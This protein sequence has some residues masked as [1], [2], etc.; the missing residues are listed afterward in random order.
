MHL[1]LGIIHYCRPACRF[2]IYYEIWISQHNSERES[3]KL[4]CENKGL[5]TNPAKVVRATVCR[6]LKKTTYMEPHCSIHYYLEA[7]KFTRDIHGL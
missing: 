6:I 2:I 7:V 3:A 5:A 1:H 4:C